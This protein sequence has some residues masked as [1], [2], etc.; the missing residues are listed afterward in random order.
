MESLDS[1]VKK[2]VELELI[3][4]IDIDFYTITI[5]HLISYDYCEKVKENLFN[6]NYS[7][8]LQNRFPEDSFDFHLHPAEF[9]QWKSIEFFNHFLELFTVKAEEEI[10]R[11]I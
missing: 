3:V 7:I 8:R 2:L 11:W 9:S 4:K 6:N 10:L 1:L 5:P